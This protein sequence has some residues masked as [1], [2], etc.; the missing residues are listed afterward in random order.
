MTL[1]EAQD[2]LARHGMWLE[3]DLDGFARNRWVAYRRRLGQLH[4]R[5]QLSD[6]HATWQEA[7]AEVAPHL[8]RT[9]QE[10]PGGSATPAVGTRA[11][12]GRASR[13]RPHAAH[14]GGEPHEA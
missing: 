3:K 8:A 6:E 2:L 14:E 9:P 5:L 11:T 4:E 13:A 7:F 1:L 10:A 12:Q